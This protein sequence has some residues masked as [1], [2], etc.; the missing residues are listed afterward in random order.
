[1]R[2]APL[3]NRSLQRLCG[4]QFT[5]LTATYAIYF[6][7][8]ALVEELTHSSTQMGLMILSSTLPGFLFGLM[9]GVVA[10]RREKVE[11]LIAS[12]ALRILVALLFLAAV[13]F[14]PPTYLLLAVYLS[15]FCLSALIQFVISAESA[16]IPAFVTNDKLM[17]ANSLFNLSS[18]ASQGAGFILLAPL[19]LKLGGYQAVGLAGAIA[20]LIAVI[21]LF[22]LPRERVAQAPKRGRTLGELLAELREGWRFIISDRLV[23]AA[24]FQL[25]LILTVGLML[26]TLAPGFLARVLGLELADAVYMA[27]P[28]GLGFG[29][30]MVLVGRYGRL[31]S[32]ERW[33]HLGF[34]SLSAALFVLPFL[35]EAKGI[36]LL[37]LLLVAFGL[38]LG[39]A[40][41]IIPAKTILQE[42]PPEQMRGRVI[43]TQLALGNAASTV[44]MPLSGGLADLIG[45]RKVILLIA[46]IALGTGVV[47]IRHAHSS[48]SP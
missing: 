44:P 14:L 17:A 9:A 47:S 46:L 27:T 39:F 26:A 21:L 2:S 3:K 7:S 37:L 22:P 20:Y 36:S 31:L 38:G 11:I 10:D 5:S 45:I 28:A 29:L 8:M 48:S 25:T 41:I 15:N 12:N 33:I 19:M 1:M 42:R 40:L 43:S 30:G 35:K 4:A 34:I 24:T 32:K 16:L 13:R 6:A 18:L 23:L